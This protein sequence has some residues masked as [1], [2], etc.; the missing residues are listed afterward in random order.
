MVKYFIPLFLLTTSIL[1]SGEF[2]AS[3]GNNQV[4]FGEGFI[5]N[6]SLKDASA[7]GGPILDALKTDFLINSQHQSSNAVINN[8]QI[9]LSTV[10]KI[11]L[12]PQKEGELVIPSISIDT[13]QGILSTE[14]ISIKV[15]K[16]AVTDTKETNDILVTTEV[17]NPKPY[18]NEPIHYTVKLTTAKN[19]VNIKIQN[20]TLDDAIIEAN[21]E[22][23]IYDKVVNGKNVGV[24]EFNYFI[25][26]LKADTLVIPSVVIQGGMPVRRNSPRS[27]F[28]EDYDPFAMMQGFDRLKPFAIKT[29]ETP[30][31]VQPPVAGIAPWLPVKSLKIEEIWN[32]P[33]L[34]Q[35][36]EP[37][38]RSFKISADGIKSSQLPSLKDLQVGPFKVYADKPELIDEVKDGVI[39]S[40]RKEQY[41]IIPQQAG[42]MVLPE[43]SL[44]WWNVTTKEKMFAQVPSRKLSIVP[45]Q[46]VAYK[47]PTMEVVAPPPVPQQVIVIQ[48]DPLL[49]LYMTGLAFCMLIW[50]FFL[51]RKIVKL[52]HPK[53]S[54]EVINNRKRKLSDLNP[55]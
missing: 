37:F 8:S 28:D 46:E 13:A 1:F 16:G 2:K 32:E 17:S 7:K 38:T 51:H 54:K 20:L 53:L 25:T 50:G 41:T 27:F 39:K 21:G 49:Y 29:P 30:I 42:D 14:P 5:L 48:R 11:T 10:W 43:I 6:L 36:G 24:I 18:K 26:P 33:Q 31:E 15:V 40:Y 19:L 3:V 22:P 52:N 12:V 35:V 47:T 55:T 34:M 4:S 23:K 44:P 9:S 45:S